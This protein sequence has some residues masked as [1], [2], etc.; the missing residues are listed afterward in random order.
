VF[1]IG[2]TLG[3]LLAGYVS[4]LIGRRTSMMLSVA[5]V[6]QGVNVGAVCTIIPVYVGEI[7]EP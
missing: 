6:V 7:D 4:S 5:R 3:A 1:D 2:S